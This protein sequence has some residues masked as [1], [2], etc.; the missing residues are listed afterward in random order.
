MLFAL[1][2]HLVPGCSCV[3]YCVRYAGNLGRSILDYTG[4]LFLYYY[5]NHAKA[6]HYFNARTFV[7]SD[8][9][10]K[11]GSDQPPAQGCEGHET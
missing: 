2:G 1:S 11:E 5:T 7:V 8:H 3:I 10:A 6:L 9:A 4:I